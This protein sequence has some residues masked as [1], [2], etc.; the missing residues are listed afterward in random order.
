MRAVYKILFEFTELVIAVLVITF[1]FGMAGGLLEKDCDSTRW[2]A[3]YSA[4]ELGCLITVE[5]N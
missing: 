3:K 1:V 5:R 2:I 4:F